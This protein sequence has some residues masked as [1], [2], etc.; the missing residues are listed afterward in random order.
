MGVRYSCYKCGDNKNNAVWKIQFYNSKINRASYEALDWVEEKTKPLEHIVGHV[1]ISYSR[2]GYTVKSYL[3]DKCFDNINVYSDTPKLWTV[4]A[5]YSFS[6]FS[7][8]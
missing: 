3:C 2:D 1:G 6:G 7:H 4:S 8:F 5:D